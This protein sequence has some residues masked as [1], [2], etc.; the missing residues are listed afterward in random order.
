M[1]INRRNFLK[2]GSSLLALAATTPLTQSFGTSLFKKT[3]AKWGYASITWGNDIETCLKDLGKLGFKATQLRTNA[4][5][6]YG[7][8]MQELKDLLATHQIAVPILSGGNISA[9]EG[10]EDE[11][12]AA[13]LEG[14]RFVKQLGGQYIQAT[15]P[16]RPQ[17]GI[18]A[19][20]L[21][22]F[23][24]RM[25]RIAKAVA[26]EG[27]RLLYHNHMHQYGENPQEVEAIIKML[28]VKYAGILLDIGHYYQG[29]GDPVQFIK[30][31]INIIELL[32]IKDVKAPIPGME[33]DPYKIYK[34]VEL[35][36]G[37][38]DIAAVNKALDDAKFTGWRMVELDG[39]PDVG[40][41]PYEC[42][43]I[44]KNYIEIVLRQKI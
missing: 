7:S 21:E 24:S 19:T 32:H 20:M 3:D 36:E 14:A 17:E 33:H 10:K 25:N 41:T 38:V 29:G 43:A 27:V 16:Q 39:V 15:T 6:Q 42:A 34:F 35:G 31:H 8:K 40:K 2:T 28:D 4:M 18:S 26:D 44:S 1:Q 11:E 22:Q 5:R 30:K 9:V 12:L 37:K 13:F 23:V